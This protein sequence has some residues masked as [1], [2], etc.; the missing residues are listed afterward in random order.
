MG[1]MGPLQF[2]KIVFLTP[3]SGTGS[4]EFLAYW[5]DPAGSTVAHST[6]YGAYRTRYAHNHQIDDE[7]VGVSFPYPGAALLHLLGG[8]SN[9]DVFS[10]S[11]IYQDRIRVIEKPC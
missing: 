8:G 6:G 2:K 9:E 3:R 7:P 11:T 5:R 1:M 4:R 10:A